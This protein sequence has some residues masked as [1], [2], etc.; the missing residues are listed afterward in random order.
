MN[1]ESSGDVHPRSR[2]EQIAGE[3]LLCL[4]E[5]RLVLHDDQRAGCR[6]GGRL[7]RE[8]G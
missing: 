8:G 1:E 6:R 3:K 7:N 5:A 2:V 4:R